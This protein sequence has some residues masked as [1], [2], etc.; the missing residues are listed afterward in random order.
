MKRRTITACDLWTCRVL[1]TALKLEFIFFP[2][3][4]ERGWLQT[5][6]EVFYT[7]PRFP[8]GSHSWSVIQGKFI[9]INAAG[10]SCA[11]PRSPKGL[12]PSAHLADGTID[13]ILIRKCSHLDFFR[14]LLRHTNNDDQVKR[15]LVVF[16]GGKVT[17]QPNSPD[18]GLLGQNSANLSV[19]QSTRPCVR[20]HQGC[21]RSLQMSK[22]KVALP[23]PPLR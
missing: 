5:R 11:C 9:A 13:L 23:L 22:Q 21:V 20:V 19:N 10:M 8:D 18:F 17:F 12:S 2:P 16:G 14:H 4:T 1:S 3:H 6:K 15:K 7:T